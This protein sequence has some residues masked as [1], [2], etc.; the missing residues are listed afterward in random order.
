MATGLCRWRS[1]RDVGSK[2]AE[3]IPAYEVLKL[4]RYHYVCRALK[5]DWRN[6]YQ[7]GTRSAALIEVC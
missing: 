3:L 1:T 5:F 4:E 6:T 7:T 2:A